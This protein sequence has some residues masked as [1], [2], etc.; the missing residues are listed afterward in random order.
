MLSS[1]PRLLVFAFLI[2]FSAPT[3]SLRAENSRPVLLYALPKSSLELAI[4]SFDQLEAK[5]NSLEFTARYFPSFAGHVIE[6]IDIEADRKRFDD[7]QGFKIFAGPVASTTGP[8]FFPIRRGLYDVVRETRVGTRI[9]E[10]VNI[11][12][13]RHPG[14]INVVQGPVSTGMAYSLLFGSDA[15]FAGRTSRHSVSYVPESDRSR[16]GGS[17]A[18]VL[19]TGFHLNRTV[20]NG[21]V[22]SESFFLDNAHRCIKMQVDLNSKNPSYGIELLISIYVQGNKLV[23]R[24]AAVAA[25]KTKS[26][27][28]VVND[29]I[30]RANRANVSRILKSLNAHHLWDTSTEDPELQA[31][32]EEDSKREPKP[33][34]Y[35]DNPR[36]VLSEAK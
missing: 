7:H 18:M 22:E 2:I 1:K 4:D 19:A 10:R 34:V 24:S 23:E 12:R 31:K 21:F 27:V 14:G 35:Y 5:P 9:V 3:Y 15:L 11:G 16:L 26:E 33:F 32:R 25:G 8:A 36:F 6:F 13:I 29:K 20:G 30:G 28:F 17:A